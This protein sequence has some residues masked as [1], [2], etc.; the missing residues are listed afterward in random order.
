M[1]I[2]LTAR[3]YL[4]YMSQLTEEELAKI[5]PRAKSYDELQAERAAR[6]EERRPRFIAAKIATGATLAIPT[7]VI[8][9]L[10]AIRVT[11]ITP[12]SSSMSV[13]AGVCIVILICI[14]GLAILYYL[15][16]LIEGLASKVIANT[17]LLYLLLVG[18]LC[19]AGAI[20]SALYAHYDTIAATAA[21][22]LWTFAASY[23]VTFSTLQDPTE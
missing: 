23:G 17:P 22:T 7:V 18:I 2:M 21:A 16:S 9:Y 20:G 11:A 1:S 15:W 14:A 8:T 19:I 4:N 5:Y 6:E 3:V 10:V 12:T 13:L